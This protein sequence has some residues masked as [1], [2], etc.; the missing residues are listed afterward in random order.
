VLGRL[1]YSRLKNALLLGNALR[2]SLIAGLPDVCICA[3]LAIT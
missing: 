3:G 1:V 2:R